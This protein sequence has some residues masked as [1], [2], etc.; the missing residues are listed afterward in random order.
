MVE[1]R[2]PRLE[3]LNNMSKVSH[4]R[5]RGIWLQ[6]FL[7]LDSSLFL[8]HQMSETC[9][10]SESTKDFDHKIKPQRAMTA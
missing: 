4:F 7:T 9:D 8:A 1:K 5:D 10:V 6:V 2:K 3:T